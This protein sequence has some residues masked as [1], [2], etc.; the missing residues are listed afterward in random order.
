MSAGLNLETF[1]LNSKSP[2]RGD[3]RPANNLKVKEP[4]QNIN[5]TPPLESVP[6]ED[7]FTQKS[8][9]KEKTNTGLY[10]LG[11]LGAAILG[12]GAYKL[13]LKLRPRPIKR[14][15]QIDETLFRGAKPTKAQYKKLKKMGIKRVIAFNTDP[16]ILNGNA[17]EKDVAESMGI[18]YT[19]IKMPCTETPTDKQVKTFFKIMD[20]ARKNNEKVYIHCTHGKDRTG[21]FC[22]MY[23]I[24]YG[25]SNTKDAIYDMISMGHNRKKHPQMVE[26]IESGRFLKIK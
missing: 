17:L 14:F 13:F 9:A 12:A 4:P 20:K 23:E 19:R 21:M 15:K 18:K 25:L 16:K 26:Y 3:I 7:K 10:A 5:N 1:I 8:K 24:K 6:K 11:L 22:A 2:P